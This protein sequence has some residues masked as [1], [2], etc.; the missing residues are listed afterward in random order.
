[1]TF[2]AADQE[3]RVIVE[4]NLDETLAVSAGAGTGKT[5]LLTKRYISILQQKKISPTEIVAITFTQKAASELRERIYGE[6]INQNMREELLR[7]ELAPIGTIH[8]FCATVLKRFAIESGLDPHFKQ[9]E[10]IERYDFLRQSFLDWISKN[11]SESDVFQQAKFAGINFANIQFLAFQL[12]Q[13]RDLVDR[14]EIEFQPVTS[15][16]ISALVSH[17]QEICEYGT[18]YCDDM[19]DEGYAAILALNRTLD[20]IA[21]MPLSQAINIILREESITKKGRQT[22]W[23][24]KEHGKQFKVKV[25]QLRTELE[26]IQQDL[27][28]SILKDL[29]DWLKDF[30]KF[31]EAEK[32]HKSV[33][34][35]DDLLLMTRNLIRN[36]AE[37]RQTLQNQFQYFLIDEFQDT[38]PIQAEIFWML[39]KK[40]HVSANFYEDDL[41]PGKIFTVGD[42]SQSIYRFRNA[43]VETYRRCVENI[44]RQGRLLLIYQNFRSNPFLL[45]SLNPYFTGLLDQDFHQLSTLPTESWNQPALHVLTRSEPGTLKREV[46]GHEAYSIASHIRHLI[47]SGTE[48]FDHKKN[49]RRKLTY[50]DIA[51][52]FPVSTS[53][54]TYEAAFK[55]SSIPF[56]LFRSSS[57]FQTLEVR[58]ILG[59]LSAIHKPFDQLE[60]VTALS[61]FLMGF[62]FDDLMT[63]K[64]T[65]GSFDYRNQ[66]ADLLPKSLSYQ[67]HTL[68]KL[69]M[70]LTDS[71]PSQLIQMILEQT[72]ALNVAQLRFNH[73][74]VVQNLKKLVWIAQDFESGHG[75]N[76]FEFIE[77]LEKMARHS[78]EI[79]EARL[80]TQPNAVQLM[81]IHQSKGLEFS[82]VFVANLASKFASNVTWVANRFDNA[83]EFRIGDRFSYFKTKGFDTAAESEK[84]F[85]SEEKKRLMYVALTRAKNILVLPKPSEDDEKSFME[86]VAPLFDHGNDFETY[87]YADSIQIS[88]VDMPLTVQ[89]E[90]FPDLSYLS[91]ILHGYLRTT[92]TEQKEDAII[93]TKKPYAFLSRPKLGIAF[94]AY[95]ERHPMSQSMVNEGI[96]NQISTE[97]MIDPKDLKELVGV[98]L[99]S[100]LFHRLKAS[101]QI[102]REVAFSFFEQ[103]QL[104]EGY[105]DLMFEE[106]GKWNIVDLKTDQLIAK[107]LQTR[108]DL[109][110]NQLKIYES[111]LKQL[112]IPVKDKI[113][114]FVRLN[115]IVL[116]S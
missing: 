102:H 96:L 57:F 11:V 116:V 37:V 32:R 20:G 91:S 29:V 47:D 95:V 59:I 88:P 30:L 39:S 38:D 49:T 107:D 80:P 44:Q 5:T 103:N 25:D 67:I 24:T 93:Q 34:D 81:T 90:K 31:I 83:L 13:Y 72:S 48:I 97:A 113:L 71:K 75:T 27:S 109:Y 51:I 78:D 16:R 40:S 89:T 53:M 112:G 26:T 98:F 50:T 52:L 12:Y 76:V 8:S 56:N 2:I 110:K 77:W 28:S 4:N 63:M 55:A 58:S 64:K 65:F 111:A 9:M 66:N 94:H 35:F 106:N 41:I 101:K 74:Q 105:I 87:N 17:I 19:T 21:S 7:I 73:K 82:V 99:Q 84:K 79:T 46:R 70:S 86:F 45:N 15:T 18:D 115:E 85:L 10:T 100:D 61:S 1:M 3:T 6:M 43:S 33:L 23:K 14:I 22:S 108:A 42:A 60:V 92:A 114:Y 36:N 69:S 62:S 104:F 68:Q 54:E